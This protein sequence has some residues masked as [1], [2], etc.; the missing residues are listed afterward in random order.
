MIFTSVN[1]VIFVAL[2]ADHP[3]ADGVNS[4]L[5]AAMREELRNAVEEIRMELGQVSN[6]LL[7]F[8]VIHIQIW[9]I[10]C[11]VRCN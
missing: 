10:L 2:Q 4:E 9:F 1:V 11:Y 8:F 7:M 6:L 3:A 5:Y